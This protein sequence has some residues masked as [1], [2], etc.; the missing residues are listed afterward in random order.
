MGSL[1][2]AP[3]EGPGEK[4]HSQKPQRFD[5]LKASKRHYGSLFLLKSIEQDLSI[6]INQKLLMASR[7]DPSQRFI[8]LFFI[9]FITPTPELISIVTEQ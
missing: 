4:Q 5:V 9:F 3:C 6:K 1:G 7:F 8:F 2:N